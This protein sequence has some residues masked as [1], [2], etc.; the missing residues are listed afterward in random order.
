MKSYSINGG[1]VTSDILLW[2]LIGKNMMTDIRHKYLIY[3]LSFEFMFLEE[4]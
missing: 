4:G 3:L 2:P 1:F